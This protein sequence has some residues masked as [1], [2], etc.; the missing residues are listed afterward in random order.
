VLPIRETGEYDEHPEDEEGWYDRLVK[1]MAED[2]GMFRL[3][4]DVLAYS[5]PGYW[6]ALKRVVD[7]RRRAG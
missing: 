5:P 7:D 6:E 2:G 3:Y 1:T 4:V